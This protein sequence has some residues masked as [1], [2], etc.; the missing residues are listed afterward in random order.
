MIEDPARIAVKDLEDYHGKALTREARVFYVEALASFSPPVLADAV[1]H[2]KN[3]NS[4]STR[5]PALSQLRASVD[6]SRNRLWQRAKAEEIHHPISQPAVSQLDP[7]YQRAC[8][9]LIRRAAHMTRQQLHHAFIT[10]HNSWP[11]HHWDLAAR[12]LITNHHE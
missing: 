10:H 2:W 7:A 11:D 12:R 5:F 6:E 1:R 9:D 8:W 3:Q 4:P